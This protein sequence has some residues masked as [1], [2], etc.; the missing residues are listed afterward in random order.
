MINLYNTHIDS[1]SIHRVGNK[2]RNEAIFLSEN[3][4]AINDEIT[5]LL[6]EFFLKPFRD[7]E[8]NYYQF[9]HEIDLDYNEMYKFSAEVFAN[10]SNIHD[11]SKRL[12]N[13]CLSNPIIRILRMVKFMLRI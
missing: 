11:V 3:T 6:K 13:T 8:E 10:P 1:L 12:R 4:F 9:A 7:K 2:S 5:P